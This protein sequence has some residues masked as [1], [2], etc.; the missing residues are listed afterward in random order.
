[1]ADRL[2]LFV[3]TRVVDIDGQDVVAFGIDNHA[4]V[5]IMRCERQ[6]DAKP[7]RTVPKSIE[8]TGDAAGALQSSA[9]S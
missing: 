8:G 1:M 6:L 3:G 2:H 7:E 4:D 9:R 5:E